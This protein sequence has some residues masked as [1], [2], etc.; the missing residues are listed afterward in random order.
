M[1]LSFYRENNWRYLLRYLIDDSNSLENSFFFSKW[2]FDSIFD[3]CL[4]PSLIT[5][6]AVSYRDDA[7]FPRRWNPATELWDPDKRRD[8][9]ISC[10]R[11]KRSGGERSSAANRKLA[12]SWKQAK[13]WFSKAFLSRSMRASIENYTPL[14]TILID[15]DPR[16]AFINTDFS[17]FVV[18]SFGCTRRI[19]VI[20]FTVQRRLSPLLL[21]NRAHPPS[22]RHFSF[23]R[24]MYYWMNQCLMFLVSRELPIW[25]VR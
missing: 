23:V 13:V 4:A 22:G 18:D 24:A 16:P 7:T 21:T 6:I 8:V 17:V 9:T 15:D 10:E 5:T 20:T 2:N 12:T 25:V 3:T 19:Y 11:E 14:M 1:L